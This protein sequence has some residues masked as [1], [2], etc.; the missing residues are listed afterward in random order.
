MIKRSELLDMLAD[1]DRADSWDTLK[2]EFDKVAQQQSVIAR[3][4]EWLHG[5]L[6]AGEVPAGQWPYLHVNG[7]IKLVVMELPLTAARLTLHYWPKRSGT[8]PSLHSRPH[9]HRFEF[10]SLLLAGS[11]LFEEYDVH[12]GDIEASTT[13]FEYW[14]HLRGRFAWIR[15]CGYASLS[16]ARIVARRPMAELY[17]TDELTVHA[18]ETE[19]VNGCATLVLRGPR[20]RRSANVYYRRDDRRPAIGLQ[21]G[22][23]VTAGEMSDHVRAI[24]HAI[25]SSS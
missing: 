10:S 18:A 7:F 13:E 9:N 19:M 11:Q 17:H 24:L 4:I 3:S 1:M 21:L 25:Q 15:R 6:Q 5:S 12:R 14:P 8:D 23:K 2:G 20:T 16:T 22:S